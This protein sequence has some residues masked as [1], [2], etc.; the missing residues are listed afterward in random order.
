MLNLSLYAIV[1][2]EISLTC[3]LGLINVTPHM[4]LVSFGSYFWKT[5]K[6]P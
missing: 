4:F 2:R 1:F 6:I 3:I 5:G